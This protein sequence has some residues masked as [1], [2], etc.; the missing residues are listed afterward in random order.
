[1]GMGN[2]RKEIVK[3]EI[4]KKVAKKDIKFAKMLVACG[5]YF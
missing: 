4:V 1:M 2:V 3:K 5:K